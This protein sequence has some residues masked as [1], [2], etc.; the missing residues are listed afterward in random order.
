MKVKKSFITNSS[1][2][3]FI[4]EGNLNGILIS[5]FN[6]I[7]L[8]KKIEEIFP[9]IRTVPPMFKPDNYDPTKDIFTGYFKSGDDNLDDDYYITKIYVKAS[10]GYFYSE[11]Y[12]EHQDSLFIS[13]KIRKAS[14][15]EKYNILGMAE[16]I[17]EN[18]RN[19]LIPDCKGK[20]IYEQH[21]ASFVGDGWGGD[22][23]GPYEYE[24]DAIENETFIKKIEYK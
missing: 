20:F 2:A 21:I 17:V 3:S 4:L 9:Q 19:N 15:E 5:D 11:E 6:S 18:F 16:K 24:I 7:H 10:K 14:Y 23:M 13:L 22:P 1:S 8:T 12:G